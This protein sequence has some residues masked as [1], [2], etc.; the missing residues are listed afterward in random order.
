VELYEAAAPVLTAA[1]GAGA[2]GP[3]V[4]PVR[5]H[6]GGLRYGDNGR[7]PVDPDQVPVLTLLAPV[8]GRPYAGPEGVDER[9]DQWMDVVIGGRLL[10]PAGDATAQLALLQRW[11]GRGNVRIGATAPTDVDDWP[12]WELK[13][14]AR[15]FGRYYTTDQQGWLYRDGRPP[16]IEA[17]A[18]FGAVD[19]PASVL[20]IDTIDGQL[21]RLGPDGNLPTITLSRSVGRYPVYIGGNLI[22]APSVPPSAPPLAP[23]SVAPLVVP[24]PLA[25]GGPVELEGVEFSGGFF[26]AGRLTVERESRLYGAIYASDGFEGT[27]HLEIWYDR[28]LGEGLWPGWPVVSILPGSWRVIAQ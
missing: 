28:R 15:R 21:P 24:S 5:L 23:I 17:D 27:D 16:A 10:E 1:A 8:D 9:L 19:G 12:Y 20:F 6:W 18:A 2:A 7:L 26:V 13:R 4:G 3:A 14:L 11:A 22:L 25:D